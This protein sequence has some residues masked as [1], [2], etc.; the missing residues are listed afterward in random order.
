MT[1]MEKNV[2]DNEIWNYV[3]P[4][5]VKSI[6]KN[7]DIY[8]TDTFYNEL[9]NKMKVEGMSA[10]EAYSAM[11]FNTR[12]LSEARAM[13][14]GTRAIQRMEK[15]IPFANNVADYDSSK[16]FEEM[17]NSYINGSI[18]KED[19]Y[20]NMAARLIYLEEMHK[21]LKKTTSQLETDQK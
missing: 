16:P 9:A 1:V 18:K 11:G 17:M 4:Q 10:V 12:V 7:G 6:S 2:K 5:Y 13:S 8:Y 15:R 14:A 20:A 19:L 21:V 3:N